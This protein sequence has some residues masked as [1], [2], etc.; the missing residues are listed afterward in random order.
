M[1]SCANGCNWRRVSVSISMNKRYVGTGAPK[2]L[3]P[4]EGIQTTCSSSDRTIKWDTAAVFCVGSIGP[5]N[6]DLLVRCAN[7]GCSARRLP[8]R[9]SAPRNDSGRRQIVL[10][11]A[12]CI[13]QILIQ[14]SLQPHLHFAYKNTAPQP[15]H[16]CFTRV[17]TRK[18]YV[19]FVRGDSPLISGTR[20]RNRRYRRC[21]RRRCPSPPAGRT[22]R[23]GAGAGRSSF[24]PRSRR[25]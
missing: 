5:G 20:T 19:Q 13:T 16:T 18:T 6:R 7:L 4:G 14:V 10:L 25:N 3:S 9:L 12:S 11:I 21:R 17:T 1:Q 22:G 24:S 2:P 23:C 8:R 15:D